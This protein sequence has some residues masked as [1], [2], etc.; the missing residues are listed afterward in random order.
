MKQHITIEQLNEL[1]EKGKV[2]LR[3][4]WFPNNVREHDLYWFGEDYEVETIGCCEDEVSVGKEL[5]LLSIGQMI[6]FL[7]DNDFGPYI[8]S[9]DNAF[10]WIVEPVKKIDYWKKQEYSNTELCDA[11]WEAVKDILEK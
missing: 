5:P 4:W 11:L 10:Y 1:S 2:R 9:N 6:E 8:T 3:E 7:F